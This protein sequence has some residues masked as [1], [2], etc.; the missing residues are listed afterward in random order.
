MNNEHAGI[1]SYNLFLLVFFFLYLFFVT[2]ATSNIHPRLI[3]TFYIIGKK[4]MQLNNFLGEEREA[5]MGRWWS[6]WA[7]ACSEVRE[8]V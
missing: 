5:V 8:L 6:C 7:P 2:Q 1:I 3:S 4:L